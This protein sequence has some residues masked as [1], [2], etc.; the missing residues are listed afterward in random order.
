MGGLKTQMKTLAITGA[1]GYLGRLTVAAARARGH[2]VLALVRRA[3]SAPAAWQSDNGINVLV[4]DLAEPGADLAEM[5]RP[6]DA[7]IHIAASLTGDDKTHARDTIAATERL[8]QAAA[9]DMPVVLAGSMAV[10][11]GRAGLVDED[12]PLEP[13]PGERDAYLRAK[14]GQE[15]LALE[16]VAQGISTRILRLGAIFGPGR[17]WNAHIGVTIG[18]LLLRLAGAGQ[19]PLLYAPH[20]AQALVRA[21]ELPIASASVEAFNVVD[22]DLPDA[23]GF[24]SALGAAHRPA[25]TLPLP[26]RLLKPFAQTARALRLPSP[27]VLRPATLLARMAP[28]RYS[29]RLAKQALGWSP[30]TSF[31]VAMRESTRG[32]E[33]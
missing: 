1:G 22:D 28:R 16:H 11:I 32:G 8:Y 20:A 5:L 13:R 19:L 23:R 31:A 21:A 4:L 33:P 27:G 25:I 14:L 6:A 26:W 3:E 17:L 10:Y 15:A 24:L 2:P 9:P 18:P 30:A 12:T 29:N 7:I